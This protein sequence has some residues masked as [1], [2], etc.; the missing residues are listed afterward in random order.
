MP[1]KPLSYQALINWGAEQLHNTSDTPKI[2]AEV[3]AQYAFDCDLAWLFTHADESAEQIHQPR[4][5]ELILSRAKGIPIAYLTGT[6]WFWSLELAINEHV[7]VPRPETETLVEAALSLIPHKGKVLD[8]GT[9]SGA[10]ALALAKERSD[11]TVAAVDNSRAA[12]KL[13]KANAETHRLQNVEFLESNWFDGLDKQPYR[14]FNVIVSNPPYIDPED[15]TV[16]GNVRE[17]EPSVA[18]FSEQNGLADL[19]TIIHHAPS[20]LTSNGKLL[21]EHGY[22]QADSVKALMR[23]NGFRDI[24]HRK[25]LSGHTRVTQGSL[26]NG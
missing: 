7:L 18:L 6:K 1:S 23:E 24:E 4:F 13:A 3:L 16:E 25:D 8:L 19:A 26:G 14:Q 9:G 22:A 10:I 2:D 11:C 20:Y 17:H 5:E 21:V 15:S 12:L